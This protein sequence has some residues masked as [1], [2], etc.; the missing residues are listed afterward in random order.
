MPH[1]VFFFVYHIRRCSADI[2]APSVKFNYQIKV[3]NYKNMLSFL[4]KKRRT[5]F[6]PKCPYNVKRIPFFFHS[7]LFAKLIRLDFEILSK[8]KTFNQIAK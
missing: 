7:L 1:N 6:N 2:L 5:V 8:K 4:K 3:R